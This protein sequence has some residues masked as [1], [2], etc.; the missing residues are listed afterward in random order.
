MQL[1]A[2][3][4]GRRGYCF[5]PLGVEE[6]IRQ[7]TGCYLDTWASGADPTSPYEVA[8]RQVL[9][10]RYLQPYLTT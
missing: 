1:A 9:R 2:T 6:R 7:T 4:E 3:L 8:S 10:E 5:T